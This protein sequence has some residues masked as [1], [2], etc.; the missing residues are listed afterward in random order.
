MTSMSAPSTL[1]AVTILAIETSTELASVA[2]LHHGQLVSRSASGAQT[3]S[4]SVPA[5]VQGLLAD[6]GL[7][8]AQCDALAYGMGPGSFTGVRTACGLAQGL[9]FGAGLQVAPVVTLMAM[10]ETARQAGAGDDVLAVLDARM[11]EV[12]WAQY[13]FDGRWQCVSEPA[14]SPAS[15]VVASGKPVV[16]GNG[17]SAYPDS[18]TQLVELQRLPVIMPQA[19]AVA[20]LAADMVRENL[21]VAPRDAQPLYLRN[22]VALTTAERM[23]AATGHA[24]TSKDNSA[25]SKVTSS[26]AVNASIHAAGAAP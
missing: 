26:A 6:A 8:L 15:A 20:L 7:K 22:K 10:A 16:C 1:P 23:A 2:L 11:G 17:L 3:H 13:R 24:S 21:L 9:G 18:F 14:L 5:M 19:E 12:Y 4:M 25:A